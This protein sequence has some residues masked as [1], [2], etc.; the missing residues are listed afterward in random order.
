MLKLKIRKKL[1]IEDPFYNIIVIEDWTGKTLYAGDYRDPK[2]N[3]VLR[4]NQCLCR[5]EAVKDD[6]CEVCDDTGYIGDFSIYWLC[7]T[8]ED[9]VYEWID[10]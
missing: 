7:D 5:E 6:S 2:V 9:N 10:Y 1:P 4:M 8:R 3:K